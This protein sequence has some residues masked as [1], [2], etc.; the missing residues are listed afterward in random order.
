MLDD[1][2][3][4]LLRWSAGLWEATEAGCGGFRMNDA[5]GVN[6]LSSTDVA[7]IR[8]AIGMAEVGGHLRG[9]WVRFLQSRQD[10]ATGRFAYEPA[11]G[12]RLSNGH[13]MW[14]TLRSL[15]ILGADLLHFPTYL[16]PVTTTAGLVRFF[17]AVDWAGPKSSHHEVLG[18][19]PILVSLAD[20]EWTETFYRK[21]A[22][23]QDPASGCWPRGP[24]VNIS[25]TFAYT[26][27]HLAA[28]RLPPMPE[29]IID[30]ILPLQQPDGLWDGGP[31][32]LTMD[33]ALLLIRLPR[34]TSH[35]QADATAA[36]GRLRDA[37]AAVAAQRVKDILLNTHGTL[38]VVVTF[39]LLQE[40]FGAAYPSA[41]PWRFD[42]DK[43]HFYHSETIARG[44]GGKEGES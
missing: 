21:L 23:Q 34:R 19:L 15:K 37:M 7:W 44:P 29:R 26:A 30:T 12:T 20:E 3:D 35:R 18:I 14:H 24:S 9:P 38:A 40:A 5:A 11:A 32:F 8:Y 31:G 13:A 41:R 33:S 36:L 39:A 16:Q 1:L 28:D 10:A 17:D 2:A 25:R 27:M 4:R 22:E 6:L 43:L 42:W